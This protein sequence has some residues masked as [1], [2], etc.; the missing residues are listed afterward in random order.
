MAGWIKL[1]RKMVEWEWY[2]DINVSRLFMHLLLTANYEPKKWQGITIQRGQK[3]TS[4]AHLSE[5]TGL[6]PMQT[7]TALNKL[8]LT[9]EITSKTTNKFT[10]LTVEKYSNYQDDDREI[11]NKVTSNS[12]N[13]QQTDNNQI[14]TTKEVKNIRN[15]E[16]KIISLSSA[17][18]PPCPHEKIIEI[19]HEELPELPRVVLSSWKGSTRESHL[20]SRWRQ[21]PEYQ[22]LE[23]WR[24]YFAG[25][26]IAA[27]GFYI[28]NNN[29]G[30]KADLGWL[31][32]KSNFDE[33]V[34]KLL[35]KAL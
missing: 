1:H 32:N 19:Y 5:E 4:I 11:T 35:S 34:E 23:F 14:T 15:K 8:K 17:K 20:Q 26:R 22:N 3:V 9:G 10:L 6:T 27:N 18:P 12:T 16:N 30:W 29:R 7:R 33:K 31:V 25:M 13:E 2:S 24:W 28:G 21:D